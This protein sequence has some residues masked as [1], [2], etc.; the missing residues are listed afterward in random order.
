MSSCQ[1]FVGRKTVRLVATRLLVV[2]GLLDAPPGSV[3]MSA[4]TATS[5]TAGLPAWN[6][7]PFQ[8]AVITVC[9]MDKMHT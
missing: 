2:F 4:R 7:S 3:S 9:R 6:G 8:G 5:P 1:H